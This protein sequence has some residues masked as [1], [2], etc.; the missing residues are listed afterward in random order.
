VASEQLE[1]YSRFSL[2]E[3]QADVFAAA[4]LMP[5]TSFSNDFTPSLDGLRDLKRKW[6]VSIGAMVKRGR[7][8]NLIN[9]VQERNL[10]RQIGRRKWRTRE[11]L[12]DILPVEEPEFIRRSVSLLEKRGLSSAQDIAFQLGF[13]EDEV[14]G[15]SGISHRMELTLSDN[16]RSGG[17]ESHHERPA[18]LLFP[19]DKLASK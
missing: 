17:Q 16:E 4:F 11:P 14:I 7:Q 10:W 5:A 18:T 1:S 15:L 19:V 9:D 2:I 3:H 12:D 6:Y 13:F 8:L